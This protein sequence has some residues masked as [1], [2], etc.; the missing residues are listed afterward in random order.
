MIREFILRLIFTTGAM[1]L[2]VGIIAIV[3]ALWRLAGGE[4]LEEVEGDTKRR[5]LTL[6]GLG[7]GLLF[8]SEVLSRLW[9]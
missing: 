2:G 3:H 8:L 7:F 9:K 1:G 6:W 5:V 4:K